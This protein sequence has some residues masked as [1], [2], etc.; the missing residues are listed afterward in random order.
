MK[1]FTKCL[2]LSFLIMLCGFIEAQ[3]DS[4]SNASPITQYCDNTHIILFG[5]SF[6]LTQIVWFIGTLYE[7]IIRLIPTAKSWSIINLIKKIL[8]FILPNFNNQNG[9]HP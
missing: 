1:N 3:T 6:S 9:K 8:D 7:I 2:V 5:N 4:T